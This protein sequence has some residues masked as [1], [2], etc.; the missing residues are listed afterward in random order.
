MFGPEIEIENVHTLPLTSRMVE[1]TNQMVEG[2]GPP[3]V[4]VAV[5]T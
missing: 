2:P 4:L 1:K 3:L 5:F